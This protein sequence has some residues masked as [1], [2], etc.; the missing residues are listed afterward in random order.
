M[1]GDFTKSDRKR[2]RQLADLAWERGL[3]VE[4]RKIAVAMEEMELKWFDENIPIAVR[5]PASP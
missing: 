3:R 4:L 1:Q 5:D 2:I